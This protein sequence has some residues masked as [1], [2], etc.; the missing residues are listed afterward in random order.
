MDEIFSCAFNY[1]VLLVALVVVC[2][3]PCLVTQVPG[4]GQGGG[5]EGRGGEGRDGGR[6]LGVCE[7]EICWQQIDTQQGSGA[8]GSQWTWCRGVG[9]GPPSAE[10]Q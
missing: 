4:C 5:R 3:P 8:K 9:G 7:R 2:L 6:D 1:E 10:G